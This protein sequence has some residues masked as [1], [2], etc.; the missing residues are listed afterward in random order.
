[1]SCFVKIANITDVEL[2]IWEIY[3]Q[4]Y[5]TTA[6]KQKLIITYGNRYTQFLE[7]NS[8][9]NHLQRWSYTDHLQFFLTNTVVISYTWYAML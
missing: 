1:M 7:L 9:R 3:L 6:H 5:T 8:I 4:Q 2:Y